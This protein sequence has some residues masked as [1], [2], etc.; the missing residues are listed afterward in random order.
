[1][2][3]EKISLETSYGSAFAIACGEKSL[4]PLFLLHGSSSNSAMWISD[5]AEY[6][7]HFRVY[8][9]DLPGEPGRSAEVRPT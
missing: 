8:A 5:A 3:Y 2:P 9:L 7:K 6:A 1:V 4:P